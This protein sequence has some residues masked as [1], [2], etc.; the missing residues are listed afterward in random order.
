[1]GSGAGGVHGNLHLSCGYSAANAKNPIITITSKPQVGIND[2]TPGYML[3]VNGSFRAYGVTDSNSDRRIKENII[4]IDDAS[5]LDIIRLMKPKRYDYIDKKGRGTASRVWGFIAQE[6]KE[7]LPNATG[8]ISDFVPNIFEYAN[9]LHS[10]IITF[11]DFNT[12]ELLDSKILG[13]RDI[14]GA[15]KQATIVDI[16]DDTTIQVKEDLDIYTGSLDANGNPIHEF[17]TSYLSVEEYDAEKHKGYKPVNEGYEFASNVLTEEMFSELDEADQSNCVPHVVKYKIEEQVCPGDMLFVF[18]QKVDDFHTLRKDAIWAVGLSALQEVDRQ[19]Q[20]NQEKLIKLDEEVRSVR[21]TLTDVP[22]DQVDTH[23]GLLVKAGGELTNTTNDKQVL[24]VIDERRPDNKTQETLVR[25]SGEVLVWVCN[26]N[27][28]NLEVGDLI[29]TSN[30]TGYAQKQ[31][32]DIVRSCTVGKVLQFCDYNPQD[33]WVQKVLTE[34]SNVTYYCKHV[35]VDYDE[36]SNI[37]AND[38][39]T[40]EQTY[41]KKT[42][43]RQVF[44]NTL[45]NKMPK[46][47]Y[48]K[49]FKTQTTTINEET[50][51]ALPIDEKNNYI[52]NIDNSYTYVQTINITPEVYDELSEEE[53]STYT[54][55]YF[56]YVYDESPTPV[57]DSYVYMTRTLYHRI[58]DRSTDQ[59]NA[60]QFG[61]IEV[62]KSEDVPVL[63]AN[64]QYKYVDTEDTTPEYEM[65]YLD[66]L[67]RVTTRHNEVYRAALIKVLLS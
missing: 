11:T 14:Y 46:Y 30:L 65:R 17:T 29:T 47:N 48:I 6:V 19:V 32:D 67:G 44:F 15:K 24:G 59:V 66:S 62:T 52:Q 53:K 20:V 37:N 55:G 33:V 28:S 8:V 31:S 64:G 50:Y 56:R 22:Y 57:D 36:Y 26:T 25:T 39:F 40:T 63:D 54:R 21:R 18:G 41:Y 12:S 60:E 51:N 42:T 16:I 4:D 27:A 58:L 61:Y 45:L 3:D 23:K 7:I 1:V 35:E 13:L 2:E 49:Y 34:T 43:E 38:R 5:A 9:V 10:N